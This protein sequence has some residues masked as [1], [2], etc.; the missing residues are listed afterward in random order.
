MKNNL[1]NKYLFSSYV[2]SVLFIGTAGA[3]TLFAHKETQMAKIHSENAQIVENSRTTRLICLFLFIASVIMTTFCGIKYPQVVRRKAKDMTKNYLQDVLA[4][5]PEMKQYSSVLE[6]SKKLYEISAVICNGLTENEQTEILN[7]IKKELDKSTQLDSDSK[8]QKIE[9]GII[10]I[11]QKH[12][13]KNPEYMNRILCAIADVQK[14]DFIKA[15][16]KV[17]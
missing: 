14:I 5:Y 11:V 3:A 17:R 8:L 12:A 4:R 7:L 15:A 13:E 10:E 16:Q 2:T 1:L 6:D 9:K